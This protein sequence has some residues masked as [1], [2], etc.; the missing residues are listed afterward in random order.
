MVACFRLGDKVKRTLSRNRD[1]KEVDLFK[2]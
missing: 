1:A 2:I